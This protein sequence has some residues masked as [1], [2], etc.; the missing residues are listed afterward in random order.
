VV[1]IGGRKFTDFALTRENILELESHCSELLVHAAEV[2]GLKQG[3]DCSL[4][5][6]LG[7][8]CTLPV[9]LCRRS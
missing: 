2:E 4:V 6:L 9:T 3:I 7:D 5:E 8:F 1:L